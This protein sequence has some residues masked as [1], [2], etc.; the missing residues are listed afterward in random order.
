MNSSIL[1]PFAKKLVQ[2]Q[3]LGKKQEVIEEFYQIC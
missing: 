3:L 2:L 1:F